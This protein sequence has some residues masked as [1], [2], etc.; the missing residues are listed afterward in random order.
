MCTL[1]T[2]FKVV[3]DS[4]HFHVVKRRD[5]II[6]TY[7]ADPWYS[8]NTGIWHVFAFEHFTS[9]DDEEWQAHDFQ[10]TN[11]VHDLLVDG[12]SCFGLHPPPAIDAFLCGPST[13]PVSALWHLTLENLTAQPHLSAW[14]DD[15]YVKHCATSLKAGVLLWMHCQQSTFYSK[16]PKRFFFYQ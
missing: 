12:C 10:L 14:V 11:S 5:S 15:W 6:E 8:A 1:Y 16:S 2:L 13:P 7:W 4:N 3:L 9:A